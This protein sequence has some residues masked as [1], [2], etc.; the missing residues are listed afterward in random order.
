MLKKYFLQ[1]LVVLLLIGIAWILLLI[2]KTNK[3]M[4]AS[5]NQ[6]QGDKTA[7]KLP[8]AEEIDNKF[9][10]IRNWS[11]EEPEILAKSAIVLNFRNDRKDSTLF[12]KN[13]NEVLPIASLTKLMTAIIAIENYNPEEIIKVSEKS[14]SVDGNN[15]GL[16]NGEELKIKDLLYIM[17]IESSNDAAM[18]LA[19]DNPRMNYEEFMQKMNKKAKELGLNNTNF[20]EPIGLDSYNQSTVSE[21]AILAEYAFKFPLL[22]EILKTSE[23]TIYSIDKKFIHKITSTNKLLGKI[24]QLIGGKTGFTEEAGGCLMTISNIL[25]NNYLITV[26]LGSTQREDDTAKLIDWAQTAWIWQ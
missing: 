4:Q 21:I 9:F 26:I 14:I 5:I 20:N 12:Q 3:P 25:N 7:S 8:N 15:G 17:L 2:V 22:A 10:P 18:A 6:V 1:I 19:E 16:I 13:I 11:I 24:P 23:A